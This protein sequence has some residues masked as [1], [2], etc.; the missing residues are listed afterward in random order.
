MPMPLHRITMRTRQQKDLLH[1][2]HRRTQRIRHRQIARDG[3]DAGHRRRTTFRP[4][5]ER[6]YALPTRDQQF[7]QR[8]PDLA[9]PANHQNHVAL[10]V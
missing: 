5:H 8:C 6:A 3:L 9:P 1:A 4:S 7:E 10:R 2:R